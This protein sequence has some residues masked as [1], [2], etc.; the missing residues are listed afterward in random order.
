MISIHRSLVT[1]IRPLVNR[2]AVARPLEL[3][4]TMLVWLPKEVFYSSW[5]QLEKLGFKRTK[6]KRDGLVET[7]LPIGWSYET[8]QTNGACLLDDKG[9]LRARIIIKRKR[10]H[11]H[12]V[13]RYSVQEVVE[14]NELHYAAF[15]L[16]RP[17]YRTRSISFPPKDC[18]KKVRRRFDDEKQ[19][20][21]W[22]VRYWLA[23]N[24]TGWT[25]SSLFWDKP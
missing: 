12:V 25:D 9:R 24:V 22:E 5:E 21:E 1:A 15:D 18:K 10:S 4:L 11:L 16:A 19:N 17:I 20:L 7:H 3:P 13:H 14:E 23:E 8:N 2:K 6:N